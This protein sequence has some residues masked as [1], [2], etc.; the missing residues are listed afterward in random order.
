MKLI[1]RSRLTWLIT[2]LLAITTAF[3]AAPAVAQ[4]SVVEGSWKLVSRTLPDG[5]VVMGPNLQ[6]LLTYANGYRHI[7]VV[8]Q[9]PDG[10][11]GSFSALANYRISATEYTE[12]RM[13]R[14][15]DDPA[16]GEG[17]GYAVSG[18]MMTV[19]IEHRGSQ[20]RIKAPFDPVIWSFEGD[21]MTAISVKG[22]FED[23]WERVR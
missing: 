15:F 3:A 16:S 1:E 14:V 22:E 13:F 19:P 10:K 23:L 2:G 7:S 20:T 6:G 4:S 11:F 12:T 18:A 8:F 5:A 9:T 21:K 17:V